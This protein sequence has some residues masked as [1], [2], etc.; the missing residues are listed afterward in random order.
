MIKLKILA[1]QGGFNWM[2]AEII[3]VGTE[4]LMG[5]ITNS[6]AKYLAEQMRLLGI[7]NFYQVTVGDNHQRLKDVIKN[8]V[9]RSQIVITT[10]GLGPTTDDITI[11][12][13]ADAL[14]VPLVL[15]QEWLAHLEKLAE[16]Y[17]LKLTN[18]NKKQAYLPQGAIPL[19]NNKG[20]APGVYMEKQGK[21][22]IALPGPPHEMKSI[23]VDQIIP[24][25]MNSSNGMRLYSKVIKTIGIG[26]APL[27]TKI[28]DLIDQQKEPTIALYAKLGE[29][30]IRLAAKGKNQ[31]EAISAIKPVADQVYHRL[32]PYIYGYD[33]E[34]LE[35]VVGRL[36][37]AKG[38]TVAVAE[39]CSGGLLA[40]RLTDVAGSSR[41]F[42]GGIVAYDNKI[43][44]SLL[45][46]KSATLAT[47]GAVSEQTAK[48]MAQGVL[49]ATG[50][51]V[52]IATTGI[53]GPD[54]GT[55][56]KPVGTV[57]FGLASRHMAEVQAYYRLF[58]GER[59]E[60]KSRTAQTALYY[61]WKYLN[62]KQTN[63]QCLQI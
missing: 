36:L 58:I 1:V 14:D 46:V 49:Q 3:S 53:A 48:E 16:K 34:K 19:T 52:A 28:K 5:E 2:R 25:I 40:N 63:S 44:E 29:V 4:L 38:I 61:L 31:E 7:D 21:V 45:Q 33:E 20:T 10:G 42:L 30:H 27:E 32:A 39:S 54:G 23:F 43:K 57:Y 59:E 26:E 22:I 50:A 12:V 35:G 9:N 41:Y 13:I 8:A 60:V 18:N 24:R 51:D 17:Q 6:N 62:M 56:V 55:A 15:N 11:E 47:W 37:T